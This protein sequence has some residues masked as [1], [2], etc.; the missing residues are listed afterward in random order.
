MNKKINLLGRLSS[1]SIDKYRIVYIAMA[2]LAILGIY[3][4]GILP[5]ESKPEIVFPLAKIN[6]VY[7]G[8]SPEDVES[9]VTD[10]LEAVLLGIDE[11]ETI[12]SSSRAGRAELQLDF[13]PEVD[14][15]DTLDIVRRAVDSVRDL[16]EG[17]ETPTIKVSTTAN[18]PFMVVSLSGDVTSQQLKESADILSNE[19]QG[20]T[21]VSDV[22]VSG[23]L[24]PE[25][26]ITVDPARLAEFNLSAED[27]SQA[28][29]LAHKDTPAGDAVLDGLHHYI[30][31]LGAYTDIQQVRQTIIPLQGGGVI[32]LKDIATVEETYQT[33]SSYSRRAVELG[34][35]NAEMK[36]AV[37]ISLYRDGGSDIIGP[38]E[39]VKNLIANRHFDGIPPE[40]D[41][42]V[43]QDDAVSVRNDLANVLSNAAAGMLIV[44]LVLFLFLGL[45][46]AIIT[47][48]IIP[49]SLFIAFIA[50][51]QAG[52]TFNTMTLLAMIIALGLLVDNGIV[53]VEN[54][55]LFRRQGL[56]RKQAAGEATAEVAPAIFAAT[57]TTMAAFIPLALMEGR[58][59]M[60]ISVIPLTVIFII[61][62]SLLIA[63]T[64][65]PTLSSRWL[66]RSIP[67]EEKKQFSL[68][69]EIIEGVLVVSLFSI[70]FLTDGKPGLLSLLTA[71]VITVIMV[72]RSYSRYRGIDAFGSTA[73]AYE[74]FLD[75]LL[76]HRKYAVILPLVMMLLFAA[77]LLTVPLGLIKIELFPV[78]DES[79]LYINLLTPEFSSLDDTDGITKKI[80]SIVLK[81]DGLDSIYSEI[82]GNTF[83]EAQVVLNLLPPSRRSW[84]T[85]EMVPQLMKEFSQVPGVKISIGTSAGGKN[86]NSPVQIQISGNNLDDLSGT[87]RS[88][89][90]ILGA[91][92]GVRNTSSDFERGYPEV[93]IIPNRLVAADLGVDSTLLGNTVKNIISGIYTGSLRSG[94]EEIPLRIG[95]VKDKINSVDDLEKIIVELKNGARVPLTHLA[96][97][98]PTSGR[99]TINHIGGIRTVT[100]SAQLLAGTNIRDVVRQFGV[101]ASDVSLPPGVGYTWGGEAADLDASLNTMAINFILALLVVFLI[102]AVQFNSLTQPLIILVSVPMSI[103]G[104]FIGLLVTGN[105]F[106]LY[107]FMG[108][109]ALVGIVVNDAIVLMDTINRNRKGG[110]DISHALSDAGRSRFAPVLATTMTTIGGMLPLAFRDENFAQLSISLISGLLASTILTLLVLPLIYKNADYLK[111]EFQKKIPIFIDDADETEEIKNVN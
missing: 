67:G 53:V 66:P 97:I 107:A 3:F 100:V 37:T 47:A 85:Q 95:V 84:T 30:R 94:P 62:S 86:A 42:L 50:L 54:V 23:S 109:I 14:L 55:A 5:R 96:S 44:V 13:Y 72:V 56:S 43:I 80:E 75:R 101:R 77:V 48:V 26:R 28:I 92:D 38:S 81:K 21:G 99:G 34:S 18:R 25:I 105:N 20:L 9:L 64:I 60:I 24:V 40:L 59:G 65:T 98:V 29:R 58:I 16:P 108:V 71:I 52:M 10:K 46:E 61:G 12:S 2:I 32:L 82:G 68:M 103:I 89:A 39:A 6:V 57:L 79:T 74:K 7:P 41:I 4:Y 76:Q 11:I 17:A 73:R 110:M 36:T 104:V 35:E 1:I 33:P 15:N 27:I 45:K 88:F 93:Q 70:A 102:L 106:G 90:K 22:T 31:V 8:A 91:I 78:M 49:F 69:K 83:R 63:L 111:S 19:F 51:N 87:A